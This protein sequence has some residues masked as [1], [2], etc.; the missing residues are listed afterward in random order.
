MELHKTI[1]DNA[2]IIIYI[3]FGI[4]A[5]FLFFKDVIPELAVY[6]AVAFGAFVFSQGFVNKN[7]LRKKEEP[8][9]GP[10]EDFYQPGRATWEFEDDGLGNP[11]PRKRMPPPSTRVGGRPPQYNYYKGGR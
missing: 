10:Q 7:Q 6:G 1:Q 5:G 11:L 3:C 9:Y 2:N 4:P 8:Q